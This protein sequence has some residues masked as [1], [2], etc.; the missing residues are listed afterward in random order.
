M[1]YCFLVK[2]CGYG[3][4]TEQEIS[5]SHK[6]VWILMSITWKKPSSH[7]YTHRDRKLSLL[8]ATETN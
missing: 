4:G 7:K 1:K 6:Y 3:L 2:R 8:R 5:S